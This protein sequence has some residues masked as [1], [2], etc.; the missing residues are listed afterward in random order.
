M[1][2]PNKI[3]LI[4]S[5]AGLRTVQDSIAIS[6]GL[7]LLK[8]NLNI[9]GIDCEVCDLELISE[10]QC[11]D[12]VRNGAYNVIGMSVTHM[13]MQA[14]LEFLQALKKTMAEAERKCLFVAGGMSATLN[15]EAWLKGGFDVIFLGYAEETLLKACENYSYGLTL[16]E[17]GPF[18]RETAGVAFRDEKGKIRFNPSNPLSQNDFVHQKY[19]LAMGMEVPYKEYW[20]FIKSK[21]TSA[22]S[23]NDRSYVIENARLYTSSKCMANCGYC[24]TPNFLTASQK[25][26]IA[27]L[28]LSAEQMYKLVIH[29]VQKYKAR[30]FSFNDED[31]IGGNKPGIKRIMDFCTLIITSK[32]NCELPEDI[33]FSCQTR[34][35]NFL[36]REP[37]NKNT[38]NVPLIKNM[39]EARFH[40]VSLGIETFSERL[41]RAPSVNK[42]GVSISD[43]H[44]VLDTMMEYGL[45]P[46]IN[47][48][49]GIPE[50]TPEELI[51]TIEQTMGYVDKPCQISVSSKM[52]SFP[53]A[54]IYA[55]KDYPTQYKTWEHPVTKDIIKIADYYIPRDKRIAAL[56]EQL[57]NLTLVKIEALKQRYNIDKAQIIPRIAI[58]LCNFSVIA[59]YL[60]QDELNKR[61]DNKL[62]ELFDNIRSSQ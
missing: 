15:Y 38:V 12:K 61:I 53:G 24:C 31:F 9:H 14:D 51:K 16:S 27:Q 7:Y 13:N 2:T 39:A 42:L 28:L 34:A 46:T 50:E 33:R 6:Y 11:L 21:W 18:L 60:G 32:R 37:H 43:Y 41:L 55:S 35:S 20:D 56:I 5:T 17:F 49:V 4:T 19:S 62:G 23:M 22:L 3:L 10:S 40:N 58:A 8:H 30:S 26:N 29:N 48:I 59:K 44:L 54:P 36:I 25:T 52:F 1:V 47:L 57:E 45:F